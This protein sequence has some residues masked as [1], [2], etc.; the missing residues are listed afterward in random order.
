MPADLLFPAFGE[1][2]THLLSI[3][4]GQENLGP[5]LRYAKVRAG[6]Y[7]PK[8]ANPGD[9]G[10]DFFIPKHSWENKAI[11]L[12]P[13][14]RV[15]IP[16]GIKVEVPVG[17]ALVFFNKSGITTKYGL[18]VGA[19]VVDHGYQ[20]EVHLHIINTNK[21]TPVFLEEGDKIAQGVLLPVGLHKLIETPVKDMWEE[22]RMLEGT[23]GEGGFGHTGMKIEA[24]EDETPVDR[25]ALDDL[26]EE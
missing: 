23:R 3:G 12:E 11:Q 26:D 10:I 25:S 20:G 18:I 14:A 2:D 7:D 16:S 8:R 17:Y 4:I 21:E 22:E 15:L 5:I 6:A 1:L 19:C 24:V 9:A 13:G